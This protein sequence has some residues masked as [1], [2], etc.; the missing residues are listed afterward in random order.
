MTEPAAPSIPLVAAALDAAA[1]AQ[2]N[3]AVREQLVRDAL[4]DPAA[5]WRKQG[6]RLS[7]MRSY[8]RVMDVNWVMPASGDPKAVGARWFE[9]GVLNVSFNCIDRH[10][11]RLADTPAI[12]FEADDAAQGRA[13]TYAELYSHVCRMANV[14]RR[15][16]VRKGDRVTLHL[17]AIP[18]AV[19]AMLACAR[20]G[21][22]H[23]VVSGGLPASVLAR[24]I[25]DSGSVCVITA[26]EAMSGGQAT[27]LKR[28]VDE[29]LQPE[30]GIDSVS[31]V[32]VIR[33]TGA[34]ID[35]SDDRDVFYDDLALRVT[36]E[37]DPEEMNAEDPLFILY[38]PDP[39]ATPRGV[40]H[41]S[42]GYLVWA[43]LTHE[44]VFDHRPGDIF[45]CL[46]DPGGITGHTYGVYGPLA[47]GGTTLLVEGAPASLDA[48]HIQDVIARHNVAALYAPASI[49][50]LQAESGPPPLRLLA[51]FG[52]PMSA[53][54]S[55][56]PGL[57][58][59]LET[60][61]HTEAGGVLFASL[62]GKPGGFAA[63]L[64]GVQPVL[65]DDNGVV[66]EGPATGHLCIAASWPA[67]ARTFH[68]DH[69]HFVDSTLD[70]FPGLWFTGER[71]RRDEDGNYLF[72]D[73]DPG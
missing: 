11:P 58:P 28:T 33:H 10:L 32:I 59:T 29:A 38:T 14:L 5:F 64:F 9:D 8:T 56:A 20:I 31:T 71:R 61:S 3:A 44:I 39:A 53:D 15:R 13:I 41:A 1:R 12:V 21:A 57:H 51:S 43:S 16:G 17:P 23:S 34:E 48:A 19:F 2:A 65:V 72:T 55:A 70:V 73:R 6:R 50:R 35:M 25:A 68:G 49:V 22:V 18:E 4:S 27:P 30:N 47:N 52:G 26:D 62:P 69:A 24:C 36:D 45:W 37:C 54:E 40:V 67:Q 7:W 66:L 42:G 60:W 46:A 63:P